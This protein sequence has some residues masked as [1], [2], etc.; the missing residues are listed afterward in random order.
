[1]RWVLV[2]LV[3]AGLPVTVA[4]QVTGG[5]LNGGARAHRD[6]VSYA[7]EPAT[8]AAGRR[9]VVEVHLRVAEGFHVNSHRPKSDLLIPTAATLAPG[10]AAVTVGDVEYPA[11]TS[12][13][14]AAS[15][16]ETLD[17]YT[18]AIVLRVPVTAAAGE[19]TLKGSL[20]YQACDQ[21]ACYPPK[22]LALA[23]PFTAK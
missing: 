16:G 3:C 9:S 20:R 19:H 1:M 14:F 21:Q 12:Y 6:F 15:P 17:V 7:A 11:G 2:G 10:D 18:G 5:D 8:V 13:H 22:V 23:V 4:A